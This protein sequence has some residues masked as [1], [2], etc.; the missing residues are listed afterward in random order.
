MLSGILNSSSSSMTESESSESD[1]SGSESWISWFVSQAGN[2]FLL[3]IDEDFIRDNF[4]LYGLREMFQ[5]YDHALA[6]ILD[7][8]CPG[9]EDLQ[10]RDYAVI[11]KDAA[12]LYGMIHQRFALSPRG[13]SLLKEKY[14]RNEYGTCPRILC[15]GQ[16]CLPIGLRDDPRTSSARLYCPRCEQVYTPRNRQVMHLDGAFFGTSLPQM[17]LQTYPDQLP[18]EA[19]TPF[20][21]KIFGFKVHTHK[22]VVNAK[23]NND[24]NEVR[25]PRKIDPSMVGPDDFDLDSS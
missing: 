18:L 10:D 1:M 23:L 9:E 16:A 12:E 13:L 8:E 2:E 24:R 15:D 25:I 21:A 4:N 11:Y 3:E 6:M 22:S 17:F 20:A 5:Y 7:P 14:I 19:P